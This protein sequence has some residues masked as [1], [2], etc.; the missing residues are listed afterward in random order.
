LSPGA[1]AHATGASGHGAATRAQWRNRGLVVALAAFL[2]TVTVY[3]QL[4]DLNHISALRTPAAGL[5]PAWYFLEIEQ[6]RLHQAV[7][8][9]R[10]GSPWQQRLLPVALVEGLRRAFPTAPLPRLFVAVRWGQNVAIF[11]V[12]ALYLSSLGLPPEVAGAGLAALA[13]SMCWANYNA[14]L[15]FDTYFDLLFYL[16]AGTLLARGRAAAV[17]PLAWVAAANRETA[18]LLPALAVAAGSGTLRA[19][20]RLG[21]VMLLGQLAVVAAIHVASGPQPVIVAEGRLP[22]LAMLAYN[23]CRPVTWLNL[24]VTFLFVPI[25]ALAA[26]RRWP[27]QLRQS[28]LAVVPLWTAVHF[29]AALAAETRLFLVPYGLVLLPGALIALDARAERNRDAG[30]RA[31]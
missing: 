29:A 16:A 6:R 31:A 5:A 11:V 25:V 1:I 18:L 13:W 23:L 12:T 24:A 28:F 22:G 30:G 9:R 27:R 8:D 14:G 17:V 20:L 7:L 19:R 15:A 2:A 21:A 4:R 26:W 10:A 3:A